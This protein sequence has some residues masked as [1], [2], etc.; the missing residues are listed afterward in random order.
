M[1]I[2]RSYGRNLKLSECFVD[3]YEA[4]TIH[5]FLDG[6]I[7]ANPNTQIFIKPYIINYLKKLGILEKCEWPTGDHY[8]FASGEQSYYFT[9]NE[10]KRISVVMNSK[11]YFQVSHYQNKALEYNHYSRMTDELY[12]ISKLSEF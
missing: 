6:I 8:G 2:E 10:T 5:H 1:V 11:D 7:E 3:N 4:K 12:Y 9:T